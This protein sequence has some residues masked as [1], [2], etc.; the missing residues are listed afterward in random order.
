MGSIAELLHNIAFK[1]RVHYAVCKIAWL[2]LGSS[3]CSPV[4]V[5]MY[6]GL[7]VEHREAFMMFCRE[8]KHLHATLSKEIHPL[9]CMETNWIPRFVQL[10]VS[11]PV[12]E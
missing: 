10:V 8:R 7:G 3:G 12:C 1:G 9:I 4:D 2:N 11:L 6:T 5:L